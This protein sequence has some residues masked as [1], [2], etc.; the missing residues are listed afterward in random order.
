ME[1]G[2]EIFIYA[3]LPHKFKI[4]TPVGNYNPDWAIVF[5]TEKI[6]YIYFIAE[7]KGSM[8]SLQLKGSEELKIEYAKKHFASLNDKDIRYDVVDSYDNLLNILK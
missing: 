2:D 1:N 5:D 6:K 4:P 7:T 8:D 3:K